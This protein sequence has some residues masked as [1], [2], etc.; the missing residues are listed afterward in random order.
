MG[1]ETDMHLYG[2]P[3][4]KHRADPPE[5]GFRGEASPL[6]SR[7][8]LR[9]EETLATGSK[10]RVDYQSGTA[11]AE[12]TGATG[13]AEGETAHAGSAGSADGSEPERDP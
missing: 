13:V 8:E 3:D 1:S 6:P 10:V 9:Q 12:A 7:P 4:P 5:S 11:F 2:A